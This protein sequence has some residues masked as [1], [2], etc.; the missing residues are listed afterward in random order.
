MKTA[1]ENKRINREA[2]HT[3]LMA[4]IYRFLANKEPRPGFMGPDNLAKYFLPAK[5]KFFLSYS[6]FREL[7][8]RKLDEKGPGS[9]AYVSARTRFFDELFAQALKENTPQI[10]FLGAGYDTR[11]IRFQE[12]LK[13]TQ[14]FELDVPTTQKVKMKLLRKNRIPA[15]ENLHFVPV[16]F[17][18][19]DIKQ[20]LFRAG[21]D[22]T[23][24]SLFIW[25][26]V[27]MYITEKAINETLSFV[28][29]NSGLDSTIAFDYLYKSVIQGKCTYYG[30][31]EL[32]E[33][34]KDS[35]EAFSFGIEEGEI[36]EFLASKGYTT[37]VHYSPELLETRYLYNDKGEFFGNMYGF[38]CSVHAR[39]SA[40]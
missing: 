8:K 39:T 10:I 25:E 6:F 21:Y 11:A 12:L 28:K 3:A 37:I 38:A 1:A 7:F 36:Q 20:I 19:D 17:D 13:G 40:T 14:I 4:A 5:A 22:P 9:Y 16:N 2:S 23:K 32:A 33:I 30:A 29:Q 18:K 31:R 27:T 35:G 24:K 26:G 34:V 15:P